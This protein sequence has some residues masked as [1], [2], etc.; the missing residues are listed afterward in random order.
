MALQIPKGGGFALVWFIYILVKT[1]EIEMGSRSISS[2]ESWSVK[3]VVGLNISKAALIIEM[4]GSSW[5][6]TWRK[7]KLGLA[8][9][10]VSTLKFELSIYSFP[11][12]L[13]L[14]LLLLLT[15]E[16]IQW[17]YH[18]SDSEFWVVCVLRAY[19]AHT[20]LYLCVHFWREIASFFMMGHDQGWALTILNQCSHASCMATRVYTFFFIFLFVC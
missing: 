10:R 3:E 14:E 4:K 6:G 16:N 8:E 17:R 12:D 15:G 9:I 20:P 13:Q 7:R 5:C 1:K 18:P 2:G 11:E 19:V